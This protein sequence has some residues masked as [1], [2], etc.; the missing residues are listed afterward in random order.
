MS[1]SLCGSEGDLNVVGLLL[2]VVFVHVFLSCFAWI[3]DTF[4]LVGYTG[5]LVHN[6][7]TVAVVWTGVGRVDTIVVGGG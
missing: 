2:L 4:L 5:T 1:V 6:R 3:V 7:I